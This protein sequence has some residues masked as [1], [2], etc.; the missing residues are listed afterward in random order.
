MTDFDPI[1]ISSFFSKTTDRYWA[2]LIYTHVE[3]Y[4]EK[5]HKGRL[6]GVV[7]L[8]CDNYF[9]CSKNGD[10]LKKYVQNDYY[11]NNAETI[12]ESFEISLNNL[13]LELTKLVERNKSSLDGKI[14]INCL[15]IAIKD[16]VAYFGMIGE[17]N[18][19][20]FRTSYTPMNKFFKDTFANGIKVF[21]AVLSPNDVLLITTN[22]SQ[23]KILDIKFDSCLNN[24][25]FESLSQTPLLKETGIGVFALQFGHK[26]EIKSTNPNKNSLSNQNLKNIQNVTKT[27][28]LNF[29]SNL[30]NSKSFDLFDQRSRNIS[31]NED[32][33]VGFDNFNAIGYE[34]NL[35]LQNETDFDIYGD[36]EPIS[37]KLGELDKFQKVQESNLINET[38]NKKSF[39]SSDKISPELAREVFDINYKKPQNKFTPK[40]QNRFEKPKFSSSENKVENDLSIIEKPILPSASKVDFSK[41]SAKLKNFSTNVKDKLK[42]VNSSNKFQN[43]KEKLANLNKKSDLNLAKTSFVSS[44]NE[45]FSTRVKPETTNHKPEINLNL[46]GNLKKLFVNSKLNLGKIII[47]LAILIVGGII[48]SIMIKNNN[49]TKAQNDL[50]TNLNNNLK[51]AQDLQKNADNQVLIDP[52]KSQNLIDQAN[53]KLVDITSQNNLK[54]ANLRNQISTKV[55][56]IKTQLSQ[57]IDKIQK[58]TYINDS[59]VLQELALNFQGIQI[60]GM[61]VSGNNIYIADQRGNLYK[62]DLT[63]IGFTQILQ[64]PITQLIAISQDLSGK[65]LLYSATDGLYKLNDDNSLKKFDNLSAINVGKVKSMTSFKVGELEYLYFLVPQ[66]GEL[67]RAKRSGEAYANIEVRK[68]DDIFQ[69]GTE[70]KIDGKVWVLTTSGIKRYFNNASDELKFANDIPQNITNFQ[71]FDIDATNGYFSDNNNARLI[72]VAKQNGTDTTTMQYLYNVKYNGKYKNFENILDVKVVNG[73]IYIL[74]SKRLYK[75]KFAVPQY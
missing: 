32:L 23:K 8:K 38:S 65:I 55:V 53:K 7:E 39:F 9:D 71:A 35:N 52:N 73:D 28:D 12:L 15:L 1:K 51:L 40:L 66:T 69:T 72:I 44:E 50:Y 6:F 10:I 48:A 30:N 20:I 43:I 62:S 45:K 3:N 14:D 26:K 21:S 54:D 41:Y 37:T 36:T 47:I 27:S 5:P 74:D 64:T 59:Y 34:Q 29:E 75:V 31:E 67:K 17:L 49:E 63:N 70:V 13:K 2:S 58:N 16:N 68:Q 33:K 56:E 61:E 4:I 57:I 22:N 18:L 11:S 42:N 46:L 19:E 24:M 60:L 25:N